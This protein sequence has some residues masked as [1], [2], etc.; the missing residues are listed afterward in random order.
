MCFRAKKT[1]TF[2]TVPPGV[3]TVMHD[4]RWNV[5]KD[6]RL[7]VWTLRARKCTWISP[8]YELKQICP[9]NKGGNKV[10]GISIE[11]CQ[12]KAKVGKSSGVEVIQRKFV[13]ALVCAH[14]K[15]L[16]KNKDKHLLQLPTWCHN[17]PYGTTWRL[18]GR[19][20]ENSELIVHL[21]SWGH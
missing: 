7:K 18:S 1:K 15:C 12:S 16:A 21:I 8:Q 2:Y 9:Q 13:I 3:G 20:Q 4:L 14:S 19:L 10:S 6:K 5:F 11:S 17:G